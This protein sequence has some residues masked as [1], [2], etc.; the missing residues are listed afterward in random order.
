M[1]MQTESHC[2]STTVNMMPYWIV[3]VT[4]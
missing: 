1:M 3:T 2:H 4:V